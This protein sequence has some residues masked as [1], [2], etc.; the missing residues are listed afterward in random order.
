MR[1]S[2]MTLIASVSSLGVGIGGALV[3]ATNHEAYAHTTSASSP[4]RAHSTRRAQHPM[5]PAADWVPD[6][7]DV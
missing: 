1:A 6:Y 7:V 5:E 3:P 4:N 2:W